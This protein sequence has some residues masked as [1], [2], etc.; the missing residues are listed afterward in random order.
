MFK[1]IR[2]KKAEPKR[3]RTYLGGSINGNPLF[4]EEE[5]TPEQERDTQQWLRSI[6]AK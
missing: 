3:T 5:L 6:G 4:V 2:K 1:W